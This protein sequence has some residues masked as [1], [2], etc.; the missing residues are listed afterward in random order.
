M[1][2]ESPVPPSVSGHPS[3]GTQTSEEVHV[4]HDR[5]SWSRQ[6]RDAQDLLELYDKNSR[7]DD[8]ALVLRAFLDNLPEAGQQILLSEIKQHQRDG[9][10]LRQLRNFLVDAVLKPSK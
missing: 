2:E 9:P 8:T 1:S 5:D 6:L 7:L 4:R 10:K 3:P